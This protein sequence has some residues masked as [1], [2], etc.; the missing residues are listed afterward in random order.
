[1]KT[2]AIITTLCMAATL[3]LNAQ[4]TATI[5]LSE[6]ESKSSPRKF[7]ASLPNILAAVSMADSG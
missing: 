7:T 3:G 1:M 2:K 4:R 6:E 5:S